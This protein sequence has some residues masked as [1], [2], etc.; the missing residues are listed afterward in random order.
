MTA[1]AAVD[2]QTAVAVAQGFGEGVL[3]SPL[4]LVVVT[5]GARGRGHWLTAGGGGL[6][7][8]PALPPAPLPYPFRRIA[9]HPQGSASAA[10]EFRARI[11]AATMSDSRRGPAAARVTRLPRESSS[12]GA[13]AGQTDESPAPVSEAEASVPGSTAAGLPRR[14]RRRSPAATAPAVELV[15]LLPL[16]TAVVLPG[17]QAV[18]P[19]G[20]GP[21]VAAVR[22]AQGRDGRL[23]LCPQRDPECERPA[24]SDLEDVGTVARLVEVEP[25]GAGLRVAVVGL[26]R[27]RWIAP[28][29]QVGPDLPL[30][31]VLTEP[32]RPECD[33]GELVEAAR[34]LWQQVRTVPEFRSAQAPE[35]AGLPPLQRPGALADVLGA[36]F[37]QR[38]QDRLELLRAFDSTARLQVLHRLVLPSLPRPAAD[39][40]LARRTLRQMQ[41]EQRRYVLREQ[42]KTI[43]RELG[44]DQDAEVERWRQRLQ[45][46]H[47]PPAALEAGLREAARMERMPPMS[48]EAAIARSYLEWLAELPWARRSTE[49][50]DLAA[51]RRLLDA[52][53]HGLEGVKERILEYLAVHI[54]HQMRLGAAAKGPEAGVDGA[55]AAGPPGGPGTALCLAGPPGTGKTS[56]AR[57]MAEALGRPF[58]RVALG[59]VR[60]EAEIRGHRR[61]YVGALPGRIL[62]GIRR[63]GACN[64]VMLLDE[65]DKLGDDGRGDPA[66][67]LLEVLD[68][69]QQA[70]FSDHYLDVPFDLSQVMFMATANDLGA[71]PA[72]LRDRLEVVVLPPYTE[73]EKVAI[74]LHHLLPRQIALHALPLGVLSV[75]DAAVRALVRGYTS[76]AGVRSLDRQL[77]ALC[78]KAARQVLADPA[79]RMHVTANNLGRWL[80]RP[81]GGDLEGDA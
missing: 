49:R 55:A 30:Q 79:A 66:A 80:G 70:V 26:G 15:P 73:E 10:G 6:Q 18:L 7:A 1:V 64:P 8:V 81:S 34:W 65:I 68:P 56:L 29:E 78:R 51:A 52:Q 5:P 53:H 48:A 43:R 21:S 33:G 37:L 61:T 32:E 13:H 14:G 3:P 20:R 75:T 74:A 47:L 76:E 16:R 71:L 9:V 39:P 11:V 40:D 36:R 31:G 54:L 57:S 60:D 77:A 23:L 62:A 59:G 46:E 41:E 35:A 12:S 72:A 69:E 45:A 22:M 42:L 50:A 4:D 38:R 25:E 28:V 67:A 17:E 24:A 2:R 27:A 63:A 44:E 19:V 58:V